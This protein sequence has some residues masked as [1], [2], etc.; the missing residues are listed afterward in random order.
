MAI[1]AIIDHNG[2][3]VEYVKAN[4]E[5]QALCIYLANH[6]ELTDVMLWISA[7]NRTWKL[8]EYDSEEEYL[9]AR[10]SHDL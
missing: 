1:F 2:K 4:N 9:T 7:T 3:T 10:K 5:K 8:A 6:D